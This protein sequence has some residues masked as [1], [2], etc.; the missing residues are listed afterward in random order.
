MGGLI[1]HRAGGWLHTAHG[2]FLKARPLSK[3]S[4]VDIFIFFAVVVPVLY[5][6]VVRFD[7]VQ[8]SASSLPGRPR[9]SG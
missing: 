9:F 3:I 1:A 2:S 5:K 8:I 4:R 7:Q 6:I